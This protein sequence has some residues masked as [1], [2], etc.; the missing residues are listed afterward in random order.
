MAKAR[1]NSSAD[2]CSNSANRKPPSSTRR[3]STSGTS[4]RISSPMSA[5]RVKSMS[6]GRL[7]VAKAIVPGGLA[8]WTIWNSPPGRVGALH[9]DDVVDLGDLGEQLLHRRLDLGVVDALL[10]LEHDLARLRRA[11]A[12]VELG[13]DEREAL[14]RLEPVEREVLAVGVA[15][16][17]RR[18]R[19]R[20]TAATIQPMT[21]FQRWSWHQVPRRRTRATS[22]VGGDRA[23][24]QATDGCRA[25]AHRSRPIFRRLCDTSCPGIA[26]VLP[27]GLQ[28]RAMTSSDSERIDASIASLGDWRGEALAR[29]RKLIKEAD[30]GVVEEVKWVKPSNPNGVPTWSTTGSSAPARSTR[31]TSSSRSCTAARSTTPRA[32]Q[33]RLR[34]WH[35][36]RHR[37]PRGRDHRRQGVQGAHQGRRRPQHLEVA[38]ERDALPE[39]R[40]GVRCSA[41]AGAVD[42][43]A[44][45][46][47]P[48]AVGAAGPWVPGPRPRGAE[49]RRARC[50]CQRCAAGVWTASVP[51]WIGSS[52]LPT[53]SRSVPVHPTV[54]VASAGS[55]GRPRRSRC[56]GTSRSSR[57]PGGPTSS[58]STTSS[59]GVCSSPS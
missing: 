4:S 9:R 32:L 54:L 12:V 34:W 6:S 33:R 59:V 48:V 49:S 52:R 40:R 1:P 50:S 55:S 47:A 46:R 2:G 22:C 13:L 26:M 28:R 36:A 3:P 29:M 42:V 31:P 38:A 15:D 20:R 21:T 14:G 41:G 53:R 56:S 16:A 11:A 27:G 39:Q 24:S 18:R 37:H 23:G 45:V 10:G 5:A 19:C 51:G 57:R 30:K 17:R 44:W 35:P 25:G 58:C 43:R 8:A 7:T